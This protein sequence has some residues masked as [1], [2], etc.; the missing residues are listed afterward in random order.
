MGRKTDR[1][2]I[3]L[4]DIRLDADKI[5]ENIDNSVFDTNMVSNTSSVKETAKSNVISVS[6]RGIINSFLKSCKC[7]KLFQ[8]D[9]QQFIIQTSPNIM[10]DLDLQSSPTVTIFHLIFL[11]KKII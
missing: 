5:E 11:I 8:N 2:K 4:N 1:M 7:H 6:K 9:L 3:I 10:H